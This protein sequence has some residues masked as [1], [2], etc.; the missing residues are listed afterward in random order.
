MCACA[1]VLSNTGGMLT[2]Q[3][4]IR[5][6]ALAW[7]GSSQCQGQACCGGDAWWWRAALQPCSRDAATKGTDASVGKKLSLLRSCLVDLP[8][9]QLSLSV[10]SIPSQLSVRR[11]RLT[12]TCST[13]ADNC[14]CQVR[15]VL[16]EAGACTAPAGKHSDAKYKQ[17]GSPLLAILRQEMFKF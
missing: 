16:Q 10:H 12:E 3:E 17:T 15:G 7:N 2:V 5:G 8:G 1:H 6:R 13:D 14:M 9:F 11:V 4:L